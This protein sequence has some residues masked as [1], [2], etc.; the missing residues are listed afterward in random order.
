MVSSNEAFYLDE[1]PDKVVIVGGGYIAVEFPGILNGLGRTTLLY[2]GRFFSGFSMSVYE[3]SSPKT[4]GK[5][6][7]FV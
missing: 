2:R 7:E 1:F 3:N 4:A 5:R 6:I